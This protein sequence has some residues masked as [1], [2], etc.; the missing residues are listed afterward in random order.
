MTPAHKFK[1]NRSHS[2]I[3]QQTRI[4][5]RPD[6]LQNGA[7]M[8]VD[9]TRHRP[10]PLRH[11]LQPTTT[12]GATAPPVSGRCRGELDSIPVASN[13]IKLEPYR[14]QIPSHNKAAPDTSKR[15]PVTSNTPVSDKLGCNRSREDNHVGTQSDDTSSLPIPHNRS[16]QSTR[17]DER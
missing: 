6:H 3:Q 9:W 10:H 5:I 16:K 13:I 1:D 17:F 15:T 2:T 12:P 4:N 11:E 7:R 8:L 14:T